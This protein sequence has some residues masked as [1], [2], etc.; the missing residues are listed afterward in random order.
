MVDA[1]VQRALGRDGDWNSR[2]LCPPCMYKLTDEPPMK[3]SMLAA[4]DG[5]NSLK[6]VDSTFRS[7]SSRTDDRTSTS[8]RWLTPEDVDRFK[9]EVVN[10][11]HNVSL[12]SC[13]S[14]S[15]IQVPLALRAKS[16]LYRYF[17]IAS[18]YT[19]CGSI[20]SAQKSI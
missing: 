15:H 2:H 5:N 11:R 3:F 17:S 1:H 8:S 16:I 12:P 6:L 18:N 9:D 20:N 10:S 19:G 4:M 13:S 7:G 14:F